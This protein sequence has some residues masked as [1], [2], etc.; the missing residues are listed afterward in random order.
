ML[1]W[2]SYLA[3]H[4]VDV[5]LP[6]L[7]PHYSEPSIIIHKIFVC[8]HQTR[9]RWCPSIHT[10]QA[11]R[12]HYVPR[13][14]LQLTVECRLV[15]MYRYIYANQLLA[16]LYIIIIYR[17]GGAVFLWWRQWRVPITQ[18]PPRCCRSLGWSCTLPVWFIMM[19]SLVAC[20]TYC[21]CDLIC[22]TW[23]R[24]VRPKSIPHIV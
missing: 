11:G 16:I 4:V 23:D 1:V 20:D 19:F 13:W 15:S 6:L 2:D 17:R 21:N 10:R 24:H 9:W 22:S 7:I 5:Y 18:L 14:L 12:P 3:D 8:A